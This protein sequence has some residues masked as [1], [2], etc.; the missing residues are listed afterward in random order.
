MTLFYFSKVSPKLKIAGSTCFHLKPCSITTSKWKGINN[1]RN[2]FVKHQH[3]LRSSRLGVRTPCYVHPLVSSSRRQKRG[4]YWTNTIY[5]RAGKEK[6]FGPQPI[7]HRWH[8]FRCEAACKEGGKVNTINKVSTINHTALLS[9]P[10][11][12]LRPS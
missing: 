7:R 4:S 10:W 8:L 12:C 2:R 11:C 1:E 6:E 9:S 3:P 5:F